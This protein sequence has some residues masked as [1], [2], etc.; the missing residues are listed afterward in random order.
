MAASTNPEND[1]GA[2]LAQSEGFS[3]PERGDLL[4]GTVVSVDDQGVIVDLGLKRDGVVPRSDSEKLKQEG[5]EFKPGDKLAVMVINPE[6]RDGNLIVSIHQA[7]QNQDWVTADEYLAS[8]KIWEGEVTGYNRGGLIVPFGDLR[9]FVPASH[10]TDLPRNMPEEERQSRMAALVGQRYGFKVVEV[11]RQRRRLVLSQ[12]D[13]QREWRD[14]QKAKLLSGLAEGQIRKGTVTGLRDFGAFV[15]LGGAD[16]LIH[17][18]EL[19]WRRVKHPREVLSVGQEVEALVVKV[20]RE[21]KRIGLS[22]KALQPDPWSRVTE[23]FKVGQQVTGT[24]TRQTTFGMFVDLGEG[25]EGLLHTSQIPP[26]ADV[27]E[28]DAV[29]V[30]VV[31]IEPDRQRIGLSLI[32]VP[33]KEP[34]AV[35]DTGESPQ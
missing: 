22:L 16:G 1:M 8:G 7:R 17:V 30:R 10:V 34:A 6:D 27:H 11:D 19:A 20:D 12:R 14:Q 15:D 25:I 5:I 31:N 2:L 32:N 24:I 9:G 35:E 33:V 13:A 26:G 21:A 4:T 29:T 3:R 18:S 28:S 23:R